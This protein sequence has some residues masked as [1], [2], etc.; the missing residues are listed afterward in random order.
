LSAL[1]DQTADGLLGLL[2]MFTKITKRRWEW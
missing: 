2:N 1:Q